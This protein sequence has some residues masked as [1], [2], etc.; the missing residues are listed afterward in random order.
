MTLVWLLYLVVP[1]VVFKLLRFLRTLSIRPTFAG[2]V[3]WITGGSSGIGET[4]AYKF[5]ELGAHLILSARR[6]DQLERVKAA[7]K[8][9]ERVRIFEMDHSDPDAV[10]QR[11]KQI[12]QQIER[13]VDIMIHNAGISMRALAVENSFENDKMLMNVNFLSTVAI[14]KNLL[15]YMIAKKNGHIVTIN[16]VAGLIGVPL[17]NAYSGSKFAVAGYYD[18]LR[19]EVDMHNIKVSQ[20]YP[21]YIRT[22][23][24]HQALTANAGERLGSFD[25][26]IENGMDPGKAC[27]LII[28]GIYTQENEIIVTSFEQNVGLFLKR[29]LPGVRFWI[30]SKVI[31]PQQIKTYKE[32]INQTKKLNQ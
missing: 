21:G 24:A 15:P 4:L 30:L 32:A 31:A 18:A 13:G 7:C 6:T 5:N 27:D 11:S 28:R 2:K 12:L 1:I 20:V 9:P 23:I 26:N 19:A 8:H 10:L 22:N 25:K 3:I 29:F 14:T 16:S 17:R